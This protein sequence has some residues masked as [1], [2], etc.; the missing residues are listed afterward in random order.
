MSAVV[1]LRRSRCEG[2]ISG[3]VRIWVLGHETVAR[4]VVD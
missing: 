2:V 1:G 3:K 4:F